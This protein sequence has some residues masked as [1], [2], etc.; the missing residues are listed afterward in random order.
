MLNSKIKI[1]SLFA[2]SAAVISQSHS[3]DDSKKIDISESSF[4][5]ITEFAASGAFFVDNLLGDLAATLE[6]ANS[7]T[8]GKYPAGSL[9]TLVPP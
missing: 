9:V 8:G 4:N 3:A 2:L 5:C 1:L 7:S 6:V